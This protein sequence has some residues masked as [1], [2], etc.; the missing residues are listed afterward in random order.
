MK[1]RLVVVALLAIVYA[2]CGSGTASSSSEAD[3]GESNAE[4]VVTERHFA[5]PSLG[6]LSK[7]GRALGADCTSTGAAGCGTGLCLRVA[8]G[9]ARTERFRCTEKCTLGQQICP[10]GWTCS[11]TFPSDDAYLCVPSRADSGS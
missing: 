9:P 6:F 5:A 11:S 8:G 3:P 2:G 10:K 4:T 7:S 1:N